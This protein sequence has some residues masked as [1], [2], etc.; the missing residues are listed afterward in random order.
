MAHYISTWLYVH[1]ADEVWRYAQVRG[2]PATESFVDVYRRCVATFFATA[3]RANPDAHLVLYLNKPWP[4][5]ASDTADQVGDVLEQ[6][7]VEV[8]LVDYSSQP[9]ETFTEAWKNQ[10]FLLDVLRDSV[11]RLGPSDLMTILD[12]DTVWTTTSAAKVF[13]STVRTK[14]LGLYSLDYREDHKVN[15]L[16]RNDLATIAKAINS[17]FTSTPDYFGGEVVAGTQAALTSLSVEADQVYRTLLDL[18]FQNHALAFEEAH[19]LSLAYAN[20]G[21]RSATF[22]SIIRR[23]WTQPLKFRN[24]SIE[25]LELAIWHVPAEKNYGLRRMY[26]NIIAGRLGDYLSVQDTDNIKL[27]ARELGVPKNR[28]KKTV[29]DIARALSVRVVSK[30]ALRKFQRPGAVLSNTSG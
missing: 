20:L 11:S 3:R 8:R 14:S 5:R 19:V 6:L 1:A 7:G 2:N 28:L 18:H 24:A 25:D 29:K 12:S 4:S 27:L 30:L 22:N 13:W 9:P 16:S 10:F 23:I 15:G 17:T 26:K 21:H